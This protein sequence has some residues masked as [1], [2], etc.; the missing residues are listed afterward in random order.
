VEEDHHRRE[1]D[2][3]TWATAP[4]PTLD[5]LRD[6]F[7]QADFNE[8]RLA[9]QGL[10]P[11]S[12]GSD[13]VWPLRALAAEEPLSILVRLWTVGAAVDAGIAERALAPATLDE[14]LDA[15]LI[16][17]APSAGV[18][19]TVA[20][21]PYRDLL[22]AADRATT[23]PDEPADYVPGVNPI[24]RILAT[25]TVRDSAARTLDLGTG[26]GIQALAAARHSEQVLATDVNRRALAYAELNARLNAVTNVRLVEGSWF[27]AVDED[28]FDLIL[29]NPPF[30]VSPDVASL[31]RD[32]DLPTGGLGALLLAEAARRLAP[33]GFAHVMCEWG[34]ADGE[35][36]AQTPREWV[37]GTG[38]DALI[39]SHQQMDPVAH[40]VAWNH[41]LAP[42]D[43]DAFE[44]SV[45][46]WSTHHAA[47]GF[48]SLHG[49]IVTLRRRTSGSPWIAAHGLRAKSRGEAGPHIKAVFAGE[50]LVRSL[51]AP[52]EVLDVPLAPAEGVRL[53]QV[54]TRRDERW[55]QRPATL[56]VRP[57]LGLE[58][59]VDADALDLLFALD[60]RPVADV[61]RDVAQRK[62]REEGTLRELAI[63]A[64]PDLVRKGFVRAVA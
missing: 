50:D 1:V 18:R 52:R 33:G 57:G 49:G 15:G 19:A 42:I 35:D 37:A 22:I 4:A 25:H 34:I 58:G 16:E 36:W 32:S 3:P 8:D 7:A 14:L 54:L 21:K 38:C 63:S 26:N 13:D 9:D 24:A 60:G 23:E 2:A 12:G 55:R 51:S 31:Y 20:M 64:L 28:E 27:D 48:A 29:A 47:H 41:R 39:L 43:P 11:S 10:A 44:S 45:E 40:A 56:R 17:R 62:T 53:E 30:V 6:A 5:R 46:R 59:R 61:V